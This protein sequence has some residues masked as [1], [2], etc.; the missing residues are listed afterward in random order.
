MAQNSS[1]TETWIGKTSFNG[2]FSRGK[3]NKTGQCETLKSV[4]YSKLKDK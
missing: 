2:A 3:Y 4:S 1:E